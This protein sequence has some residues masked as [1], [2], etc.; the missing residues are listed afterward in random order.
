MFALI[1]GDF[2]FY[3]FFSV[4]TLRE[5]PKVD[6]SKG[7]PPTGDVVNKSVSLSQIHM[8]QCAQSVPKN[9]KYGG[10]KWLDVK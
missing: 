9:V 6:T 2:Y 8:T 3:V 5:F 7:G 4:G 1:I 10:D